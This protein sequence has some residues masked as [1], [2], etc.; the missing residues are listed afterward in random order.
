MVW[1]VAGFLMF[2]LPPVP[3][4]PVYLFGGL[5]AV[6]KFGCYNAG[7]PKPFASGAPPLC[8]EDPQTGFFVGCFGVLFLSWILKLLACTA[9]QKGIGEKFGKSPAV[10]IACG[11]H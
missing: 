11:V 1:F 9:Q 4:P 6:P 5:V 2:L 10:R 3:G 7:D 8:V